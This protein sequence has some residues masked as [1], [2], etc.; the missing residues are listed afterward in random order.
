MTKFIFCA[1]MESQKPKREYNRDKLIEDSGY[2][3]LHIKECDYTK[4]PD[5]CVRL[6]L[7]FLN[8]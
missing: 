8:K 4:N 3:I 2:E 5:E 7:D 6:C 1:I